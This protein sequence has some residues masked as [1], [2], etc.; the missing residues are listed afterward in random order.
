MKS[1]ALALSCGAILAAAPLRAARVTEFSL[2]AGSGFPTRIVAGPD[3]R[4]WFAEPSAHQIGIVT[5]AG[6]FSA[7]SLGSTP[8]D[9]AV[10]P[11]K[12]LA[13]AEDSGLAFSTIDGYV[14]EYP[15]FSQP[16]SL[17]FGP[18][19]RLWIA[20]FAFR[21]IAFHMLANAPNTEDLPLAGFSAS[22]AVGRD[23]RIWG[24]LNGASAV[25]A[26]APDGAG[27]TT[28]P[29]PSSPSHI[30]AGRDGSMWF[31][32]PGDNAIGRITPQGGFAEFAISTTGAEP[33]GICAGPDGNMWFTEYFGDK[34]G[35]ITPEGV[36]TEYALGSDI[37][38]QDVTLG[39][40]GALW[41]SEYM[42]KKIGRFQVFTAGDANDD[43]ALDV[44]DVFFLIN[45]LYAGG[46]APK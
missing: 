8:R 4:L 27:C 33:R 32:L 26:C 17:A 16:A 10:I 25:V 5:T 37:G 42:T 22:M 3:G 29:T 2:P 1:L 31:S 20:D 14:S 13:I 40:D 11:G 9:I 39:P 23:G 6:A 35:R 28:Y 7:L 38:P 34:L 19:G 36:I 41:F 44:S 24:T 21:F 45:Y 18:D 30:A 43:G 12:I 46:P 15:G